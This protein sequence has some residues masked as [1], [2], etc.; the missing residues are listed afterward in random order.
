MFF[1]VQYDK[2]I[3]HAWS[4]F[5]KDQGVFSPF[6]AVNPIKMF[7]SHTHKENQYLCLL[8]LGN[9]FIFLINGVGCGGCSLPAVLLEYQGKSSLLG[10][11][12]CIMQVQWAGALRHPPPVLL[13]LRLCGKRHPFYLRK[14]AMISHYWQPGAPA[15]WII[16]QVGQYRNWYCSGCRQTV[17]KTTILLYPKCGQNEKRLT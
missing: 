6:L 7:W 13:E 15:T 11:T 3:P 17:E 10:R 9:T 16:A 1:H 4:Y 12:V 2:I 5:H 14:V 8:D